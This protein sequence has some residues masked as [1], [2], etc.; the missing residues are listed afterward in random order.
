MMFA[1]TEERR[2]FGEAIGRLLADRAPF[3]VRQKLIDG[4]TDSDPATWGELSAIGA[5]QLLFAPEDG[6]A[7]G[8]A[9]DVGLLFETAGAAL[10]FE[11]LLGTLLAGR[12]L[13]G[14]APHAGVLGALADG[15]ARAALAYEEED[16][17]YDPLRIA[18]TA[19]GNGDGWVLSGRKVG[20]PIGASADWLVV[21]ARGAQ[22]PADEP[23]LFLLPK[24]AFA[25]RLTPSRAIDGGIVS[26]LDLDGL[27]LPADA[28]IGEAGRGAAR[29][30]RAISW[31][32]FAVCAEA[33]GIMNVVKR[34]TLDY[35]HTR[36]QFGAPIGT[37]QVLQHRYVEMLIAI[38]E[39]ESAVLNA[40]HA[41]D[42]DPAPGKTVFAAKATIGHAGTL[43][44]EESIHMHGGIGL[45][46]ELPLAQYARRLAMIDHQFGDRMVHLQ[47]YAAS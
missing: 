6:G 4:D 16:S 37:S 39:A 24:S 22:D 31:G 12:I 43:V 38:D 8:A 34:E 47:N 20:I 30:T 45:T 35:L 33:V 15:S 3:E 42:N 2:M 28:L 32:T 17:Y 19:Q 18:A 5:T 26:E 1:N 7:A 36:K 27:D 21:S 44:A 23:S 14:D 46:R 25:A 41:L 10:S 13:A 9:D 29:L 11:P 40:A